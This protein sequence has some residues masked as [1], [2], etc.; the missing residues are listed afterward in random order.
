MTTQN[1]KSIS[2]I[3]ESLRDILNENVFFKNHDINILCENSKDIDYEIKKAISKVGCVC[4]INTPSLTYQGKLNN[5]EPS[6]KLNRITISFAEI[7]VTNRGKANYAT[8]LD[9]ALVAAE[10][11][12]EINTLN[13]VDINES[14]MGAYI[15]VTVTFDSNL[16][17]R[18]EKQTF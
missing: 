2:E 15:L 9:S 11:L 5:F 12:A 3:Q 7:P 6:W 4:T 10:T 14:D 17:F 8:S 18:Y 16:T 13:L 1:V